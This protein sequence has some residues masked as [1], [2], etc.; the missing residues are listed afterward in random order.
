MNASDN[1]C[2]AGHNQ[3]VA[4]ASQ[5]N[6]KQ[7]VTDH[8]EAI[9]LRPDWALAFKTRGDVYSKVGDAEN[10]A[11]GRAE[12]ARLDPGLDARPAQ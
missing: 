10:A 7:G 1:F 3:R 8:P 4:Q 6:R 5:G 11:R 12:A 2:S 9:R